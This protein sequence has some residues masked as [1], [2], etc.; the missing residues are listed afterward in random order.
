MI[1]NYNDFI[2]EKKV[3]SLILEGD[4]TAS[5]D[6]LFKLSQIRDKSLIADILFNNFNDRVYNSVDLPQNWIDTTGK[7]DTVS[8]LPDVKARN[9]LISNMD[10][11]ELF[12]VKGRNEIKIGR[13]ARQLLT[14]PDVVKYLELGD[15]TDINHLTNKDYEDFVNLFKSTYQKQS[16]KFIIVSGKDIENYYHEDSYAT[17]IGQLGSSCM[18]HDSCSEYFGIYVKNECVRLLVYLNESG[19]V[20]GRAIIW[21][22]DESPCEAQYFMDRIYT[23]SDSDLIKFQ[24]YA[25]QE[26]WLRKYKN[27]SH[28]ETSIMFIYK[29]NPVLGKITVNLN[30]AKFEYYPYM[31]TVSY[32]N[33][34]KKFASNVEGK[35]MI[36]CDDTEGEA[37]EGCDECGGKGVYTGYCPRCNNGKSY[38]I[39]CTGSGNVRCQE[40]RGTSFKIDTVKECDLCHGKKNR[41]S[42]CHGKGQVGDRCDNCKHGYVKCLVCNGSGQSNCTFCDGNYRLENIECPD[43]IGEYKSNLKLILSNKLYSSYHEQA[44]LE[45]SKIDEFPTKKKKK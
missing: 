8:F 44:K 2:L 35:N 4:L 17:I 10:E 31:D 29:G 33:V 19:K 16:N 18:R 24:N 1:D 23:A 42:K 9:L 39:N 26:G 30:K 36:T 32:V 40:C 6:F 45:L 38:C 25:D 21:K 3:I 37:E 12:K 34:S 14:N 15:P 11:D 7:D 20:L 43:C 27:T 41:C 5:N 22:L 13:F 28:G